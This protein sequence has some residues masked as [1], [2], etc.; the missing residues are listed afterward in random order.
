M[1]TLTRDQ[2]QRML[3]PTFGLAG[4]VCT[5]MHDPI[6]G[7]WQPVQH[8]AAHLTHQH[9]GIPLSRTYHTHQRPI[10]ELGGQVLTQLCERALTIIENQGD[11]HPAKDPEMMRLH[12]AENGLELVERIVYVD[13]DPCERPPGLG[14]CVVLGFR[15]LPRYTG[16]S[17]VQVFVRELTQL[18]SPP[19][20]HF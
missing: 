16:A 20:R 15:H 4:F 17:I 7:G 8:S 10:S 5:Q 3:T 19:T 13:G 6:S 18:Y 2:P 11:Q 1:R 9:V 14:S 12:T